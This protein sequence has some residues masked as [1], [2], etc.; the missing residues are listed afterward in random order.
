MS[1]IRRRWID[2]EMECHNTIAA[3]AIGQSIDK[4][5]R[6]SMTRT[7]YRDR[8][9]LTNRVIERFSAYGFGQ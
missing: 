2:H 6:A 5:T 8:L 7:S 1:G 9:P 3:H 4:S